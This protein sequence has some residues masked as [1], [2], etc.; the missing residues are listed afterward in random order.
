M[1]ELGNCCFE[2]E[3]EDSFRRINQN[4]FPVII[5][6]GLPE[7]APSEA[8]PDVPVN[9]ARG[10]R[11]RYASPILGLPHTSLVMLGAL[12]HSPQRRKIAKWIMVFGNGSV[13]IIIA[14]AHK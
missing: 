4:L 6:S 7:P 3:K 11:E 12:A 8:E 14:I 9:E 1:V 10:L 5:F 13:L 2:H